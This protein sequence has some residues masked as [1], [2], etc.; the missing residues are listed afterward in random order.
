MRYI[1][2]DKQL[3]VLGNHIQSL[4]D[5]TLDML[6]EETENMGLGEMDEID[7]IQSINDITIDRIVP[8]LG[9]IVYVD[10]HTDSDREEYDNVMAEL[11]YHLQKWVPN[12]KL[13]L[14]VINP[15]D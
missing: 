8:Y 15:E 5:S 10:I 2:K 11:N 12:I 3:Q 13:F 14:H 4:I 9:T 1:V 7:E 6:K